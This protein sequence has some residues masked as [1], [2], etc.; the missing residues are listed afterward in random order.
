MATEDFKL[1]QKVQDMMKYA[2]PILHQF[3]KVE[4]FSLANDIRH[5]MNMV[6]EYT[7]TEDKKYTKTTTLEKLDIENE[8]LKIYIRLSYELQ[9]IDKHRYAVWSSK[10]VEIGK[11]IGGLI[12]SVSGKPKS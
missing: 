12:K 7:I 10:V 5:T 4:K 8:K 3:P 9:Y 6:L 11:M 1:L 2:Y